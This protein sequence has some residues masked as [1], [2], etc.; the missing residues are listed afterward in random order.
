MNRLVIIGAGGHGKVVAD[1]AHA[2]GWKDIAF[3]DRGW[4]KRDLNGSWPVIA[5]SPPV[6]GTALFCGVGHNA[7]R[8]RLFDACEL[9]NAPVLIHPS[10][11]LSPSATLGNG[12]LA[13]AGA[14]VN[15]DTQIG[16]GVILNT[17]CSVDHDCILDDFTHISPGARLAG[18]VRVGQ[19]TWIGIGAVIREGVTIGRNVTVGAGAAV[20]HDIE[21]GERVAGVPARAISMQTQGN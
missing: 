9:Q 14:I 15:A 21:D 16:R 4:P 18:G 10:V 19:C 8:A 2:A 12:T 7:T 17:G 6:D 3:V 5:A 13:V 20:I 1:T 11:I